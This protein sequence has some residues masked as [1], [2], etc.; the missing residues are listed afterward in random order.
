MPTR[1]GVLLFCFMDEVCLD[2]DTFQNRMRAEILARGCS[3]PGAV[4]AARTGASIAVVDALLRETVLAQQ[5]AKLVV[6]QTQYLRRDGLL[7]LR[8]LERA[9]QHLPLEVG[10]RGTK[11]G[12]HPEVRRG[13]RHRRRFGAL[14]VVGLGRGRGVERRRERIEQNLVDRLVGRLRAV[15]AAL[16]RVLELADVAGPGVTQQ[17]RL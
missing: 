4:A 10:D 7:E 16:D 14:V 6:A 15:D 12:G 17:R 13:R 5:A 3:S 11:V 1:T 2:N 9:P 8:A